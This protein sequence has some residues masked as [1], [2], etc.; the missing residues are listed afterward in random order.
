MSSV[1]EALVAPRRRE[2]LRLVWEKERAAG[3][4]HRA[5]AGVSFG[6][7]S[8][9]LRVLETAGLVARREEGR[10]RYYIAR[11]KDLGSLGKWLES[12]WDEALTGLKT[13]AEAD[14][15]AVAPIRRHSRGSHRQKQ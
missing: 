8:Q 15:A 1:F 14:E 11:R 5:I 12:T 6:A 2:I 13:L 4:I 9:H 3:D 10:F 7:V